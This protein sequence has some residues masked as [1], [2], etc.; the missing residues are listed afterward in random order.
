[1]LNNVGNNPKEKYVYKSVSVPGGGFVTGFVFHPAVPDILYCRTDIGGI[2]RYDFKKD[3]W[4]SLI[5]SA[6]DTEV[7]KTYPLSIA[8]DRNNPGYLYAMVGLYPTHKIAFSKDYGDHFVYFE[9]PVDENGNSVAMHGNAPGRST[10]ERLVVDLKDSDILYMGTMK[11][12]LWKTKDHC[13]TWEKLNITYPGRKPEKNISFV[14]ID[15]FSGGGEPSKRIIVATSGEGGSPGNNVR[16]QSIYISNDGG[17]TFSPLHKEPTPITEG[18]SDYPGYVGQRAVFIDKYL[19]ITYTAYNIGWSNWDSYGCDT[20][21]GYDGAVYRYELN[22]AGEVVEALDITP[23]NI[24]E[25]SFYEKETTG[26]RVG[27]GMGG[28]CAD[29]SKPGTLICSTILASPDTIYRSTDYGL[30]WTPVLSG[31]KKER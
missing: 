17:E 13:K 5:D 23:P 14:E 7:W 22:H 24:I 29:S 19:Y 31:L 11:N 18:P 20:G 28:I 30:T 16:G 10:G 3:C 15:P 25:P 1:M 8:L 9:V 6:T 2:Y 21:R 27:Y 12:G 4:I 26:R